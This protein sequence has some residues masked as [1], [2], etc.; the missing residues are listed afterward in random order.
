MHSNQLPPQ[1]YDGFAKVLEQL[2]LVRVAI[3]AVDGQLSLIQVC[4]QPGQLGPGLAVDGGHHGRQLV[5]GGHAKPLAPLKTPTDAIELGQLAA[6]Q[7]HG[8]AVVALLRRRQ[9]Y[10]STG[11][12]AVNRRGGGGVCSRQHDDRMQ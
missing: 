11:T 9:R 7:A 6:V 12:G 8:H 10:R 3:A 1:G 4:S 2:D 5:Q